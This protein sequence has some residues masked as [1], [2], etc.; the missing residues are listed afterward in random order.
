VNLKPVDSSDIEEVKV[1]STVE[2]VIFSEENT[3]PVPVVF[4]LATTDV[5]GVSVEFIAKFID[6][7]SLRHL[8]TFVKDST[9]AKCTLNRELVA[10]LRKF[11]KFDIMYE[12]HETELL[13]RLVEML[14]EV[15]KLIK[16][17]KVF[18]T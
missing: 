17:M 15:K 8:E 18:E 9:E 4:S 2:L 6:K 10:E 14:G 7:K 16:V 5:L 11:T 12:V 13:F 1:L 3:V